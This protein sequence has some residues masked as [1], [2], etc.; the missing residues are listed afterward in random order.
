MIH[1]AVFPVYANGSVPFVVHHKER[2][3][4]RIG[5]IAVVF[6]A[7]SVAHARSCV[8]NPGTQTYEV[9]SA[10]SAGYAIGASRTTSV[11][12]ST[13]VTETR[14]RTT[15]LSAA[16]SLSTIPLGSVLILR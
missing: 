14:R 10:V 12:V 16:G 15:A 1:F 7:M 5:S 6:A 9:S 11:M 2:S 3:M 4:W 8:V 13:G